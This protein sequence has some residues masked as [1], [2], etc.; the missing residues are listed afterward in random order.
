MRLQRIC[1]LVITAAV[2]G[3]SHVASAESYVYRPL[4]LR[5]SEWSLDFGVGVGHAPSI[6]GAGL[7]FELAVGLTSFV[8]LGFRS[9]YRFSDEGRATAAD[10]YG[11]TFETETY[12][13]GGAP[14]SNP[15]LSLKW[16]LARSTAELALDTRVYL[17]TADGSRLGVLV[18]LP[19]AL[20]L[21]SSARIDTGI[22]VPIVFT[23][24][25]SSI[26]SIPLHLW[27]QAD[28]I[29]L[30]PLTGIRIHNPGGHSTV[31]LG[32]GLGAAIAHETDLRTWLLFPDVSADHGT[33]IFGFGV[34]LEF[35]F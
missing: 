3:G 11:R 14:F 16:S 28:H 1:V 31:P 10:V 25:V 24:P 9:G 17:P 12:D 21:G 2:V 30:G 23:D 22:F 29:Y 33:R 5:R 20:H 19:I 35:R 4:T 27:I 26:I 34:G 7:N 18:G 8:Q 6:T 32:F 13:I 15:E